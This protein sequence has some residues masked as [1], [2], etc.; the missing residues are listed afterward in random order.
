MWHTERQTD[1]QTYRQTELL[2][3]YRSS[4][5]MR[6]RAIKRRRHASQLIHNT[7][8]TYNSM[9]LPHVIEFYYKTHSVL[10]RWDCAVYQSCYNESYYRQPSRR[11]IVYSQAAMTT[12]AAVHLK[13]TEYFMDAPLKT[14]DERSPAG[15]CHSVLI[16]SQTGCARRLPMS[17][18]VAFEPIFPLAA[19]RSGS[20]APP[21]ITIVPREKQLFWRLRRRDRSFKLIV[22]WE[23]PADGRTDR[24]IDGRLMDVG[25]YGDHYVMS[26]VRP[27]SPYPS[28]TGPPS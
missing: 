8:S 14:E 15:N 13:T 2:Y 21:Q 28:P 24:P 11:L 19:P 16:A 23:W 22:D 18:S 7:N 20:A 10:R 25:V 26:F 3:Q 1:G 9:S 4:A 5:L 27:Y 17:P 12:Q 6:W